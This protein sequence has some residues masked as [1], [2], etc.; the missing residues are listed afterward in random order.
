MRK[1]LEIKT[2]TTIENKNNI[3]KTEG[4][5]GIVT[6][7]IGDNN[8]KQDT[9]NKTN[10]DAAE[11]MQSKMENS[12][13]IDSYSASSKIH[14]SVSRHRLSVLISAERDIYENTKYGNTI[15]TLKQ[16]LVNNLYVS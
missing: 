4:N 5:D 8:N 7:V 3:E 10:N 11:D 1:K 16:F 12:T 14:S 2:T 9:N 6:D 13:T 15:L